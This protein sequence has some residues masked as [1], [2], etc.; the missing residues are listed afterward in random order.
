VTDAEAIE[1]VRRHF[2]SLF[3]K[4]CSSCGRTFADLREYISLTTRVGPATSYDADLH[5]WNTP[6]PIGS[7]ALANCPCGSTL[8]LTTESMPLPQRLVLLGWVRDTTRE[9]GVSPSTLL[10]WLRDE[11]RRP[12]PPDRASRGRG[13]D[14]GQPP[15]GA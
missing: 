14:S 6:E 15:G 10:E 8:A 4:S 12:A 3:P 1:L 2:E 7:Q 5:D 13:C 11:I 9:R